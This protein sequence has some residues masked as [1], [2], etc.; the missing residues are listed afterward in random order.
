MAMSEQP[1]LN[2]NQLQNQRVALAHI[3]DIMHG[4]EQE[5]IACQNPELKESIRAKLHRVYT[6]RYNLLQAIHVYL[7]QQQQSA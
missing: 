3:E 6:I 1:I 2:D 4:Y 5:F 7:M